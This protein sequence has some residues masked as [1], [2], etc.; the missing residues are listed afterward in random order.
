MILTCHIILRELGIGN[1]EASLIMV[2]HMIHSGLVL[3]AA[4]ECNL[5]SL[6][7][8]PFSPFISLLHGLCSG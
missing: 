1:V 4:A 8:D 3:V 5:H 2:F 6:I 7:N